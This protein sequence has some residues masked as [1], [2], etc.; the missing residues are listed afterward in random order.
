M[1]TTTTTCVDG[2]QPKLTAGDAMAAWG[3]LT[4]S[5]GGRFTWPLT[6]LSPHVGT[7][8]RPMSDQ[9]R[10]DRRP[11]PAGRGHRVESPIHLVFHLKWLVPPDYWLLLLAALKH[12]TWE[13]RWMWC[14]VVIDKIAHIYR[15]KWKGMVIVSSSHSRAIYHF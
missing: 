13:R 1:T 9:R 4:S 8:Y 5:S 2:D 11:S 15:Y 3:T 10:T 12:E 6:C 7:A 14:V